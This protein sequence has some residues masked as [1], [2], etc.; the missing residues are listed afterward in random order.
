MSNQKP[1]EEISAGTWLVLGMI[2]VAG[3]WV[4][5][6]F[7][8][9]VTLMTCGHNVGEYAYSWKGTNQIACIIKKDDY[10]NL[11]IVAPIGSGRGSFRG[12]FVVGQAGGR[13][14]TCL[15][16]SITGLPYGICS[17]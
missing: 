5:G 2:V 8:R 3:S 10:N 6:C 15:G 7:Q 4:F 13:N 9:G 1:V 17:D 12:D 11:E 16:R 14:I